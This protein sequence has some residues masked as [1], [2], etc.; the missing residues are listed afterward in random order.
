MDIINQDFSWETVSIL[1]RLNPQMLGNS[2]EIDIQTHQPS[3]YTD[4]PY[5]HISKEA[6]KKPRRKLRDQNTSF[7]SAFTQISR[8]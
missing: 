4:K 3:I 2:W 7:P 5:L 6:I 1:T 8:D